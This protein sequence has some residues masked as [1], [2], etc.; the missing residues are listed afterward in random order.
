[1][2]RGYY[3]CSSILCRYKEARAAFEAS[4]VSLQAANLDKN[5]RQR[6]LKD[7]QEALQKVNHIFIVIKKPN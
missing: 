6:F 3:N 7:V 5:K 2:S 1:V 4:I